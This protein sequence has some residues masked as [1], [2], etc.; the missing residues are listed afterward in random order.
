MAR[1]EEFYEQADVIH[2]EGCAVCTPIEGYKVGGITITGINSVSVIELEP[3]P[4]SLN[5][6]EP[7]VPMMKATI[8]SKKWYGRFWPPERRKI[9]IMQAMLD[10]KMPE[11]EKA[12]NEKI[13]NQLLYGTDTAPDPD[14]FELPSMSIVYKD[15]D[16]G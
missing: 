11:I 10:Y 7:E 13:R 6:I 12:T 8:K 5:I 9:K 15:R 2:R 16:R 4:Q 1:V 3:Q 14:D